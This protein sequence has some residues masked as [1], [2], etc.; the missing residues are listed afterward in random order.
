MQVT[1]VRT[2]DR[3]KEIKCGGEGT[4]VEYLRQAREVIGVEALAAALRR[5]SVVSS[6]RTRGVKL[7]IESGKLEVSSTNPDLGEASET[8]AVEYDGE[9]VTIGFNARY[10]LDA[11]A[12]LPADS[13]VEVGFDDE[14]S[15][16]VL[17]SEGDADFVYVVMPM[18]L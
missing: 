16:G 3:L 11:L 6:E 9:E 5:V 17:R 1:L 14:V 7:R 18:R 13:E 8:L 10:V 4:L 15:P 2:L 12:V